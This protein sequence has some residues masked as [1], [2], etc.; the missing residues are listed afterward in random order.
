MSLIEGNGSPQDKRLLGMV[1]NADSCGG[2]GA[3][4]KSANA[5]FDKLDSDGKNSVEGKR[6]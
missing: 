6:G 5:A 3:R 4:K 2:W 1:G